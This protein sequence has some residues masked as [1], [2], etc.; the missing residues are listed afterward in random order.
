MKV[1]VQSVNFKADK[2]L[3]EFIE[4]KLNGLDK[5]YD[6]IV[7]SEVFLKVQQTSEPENKVVEI[8]INI[9]GN[10]LMVKKQ[11][12]TFEEGTLLAVDSLKRQV[13]K[14]KEKERSK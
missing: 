5:F 6:R 2:S 11:A 3:I 9:P 13:S 4:K 7:D 14:S 10:E 8:K 1:Y 12:K